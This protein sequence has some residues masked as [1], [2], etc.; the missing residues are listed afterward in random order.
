MRIT[1]E[2]DGNTAV[3]EEGV[4]KINGEAGREEMP[5]FTILVCGGQEFLEGVQR[6]AEE[7]GLG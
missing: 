6:E 3:L 2:S 5:L 4:E 7:G 1:G